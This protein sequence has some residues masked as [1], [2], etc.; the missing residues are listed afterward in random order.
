[1]ATS[2]QT[3]SRSL[4]LCQLIN[5]RRN[6]KAVDAEIRRLLNEGVDINIQDLERNKNSPLHLAA[7]KSDKICVKLLLSY[8]PNLQ[9]RNGNGKTAID[10]A[11]G[12]EVRE[13]LS[14][15]S[16]D[17]V[18]KKFIRTISFQKLSIERLKA[19]PAFKVLKITCCPNVQ[20]V[21]EK[22][23]SDDFRS[24]ITNLSHLFFIAIETQKKEIEPSVST[25]LNIKNPIVVQITSK[26][27]KVTKIYHKEEYS[28]QLIETNCN[29]TISKEVSRKFIL[30]I[31]ATFLR[32]F[33]R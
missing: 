1:M 13:L 16:F 7:K 33:K 31:S 29:S 15:A 23:S 14:S 12:T 22:I 11:R 25:I 4:Q 17:V 32:S 10:V 8:K 5:D 24:A 28:E 9:I 30:R 20:V 6:D 21:W 26:L 18:R 2:E 27:S 19:E 3:Q